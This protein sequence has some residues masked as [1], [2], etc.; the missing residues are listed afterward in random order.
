LAQAMGGRY[1]DN[2]SRQFLP[3]WMGAVFEGPHK[4]G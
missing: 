2:V 3:G 1:S 4:A